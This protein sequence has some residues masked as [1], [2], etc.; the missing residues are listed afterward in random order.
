MP[1]GTR[2]RICKALKTLENKRLDN[3]WRKHGNIPL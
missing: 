2:R 1:H 3:P